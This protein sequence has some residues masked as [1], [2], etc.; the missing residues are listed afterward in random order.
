MLAPSTRFG[1]RIDEHLEDAGGFVRLDGAADARKRHRR[2]LVGDALLA[3]TLFVQSDAGHFGIGERDV[4][5]R[6]RAPRRGSV[7]P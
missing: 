2:E 5:I 3:S 1:L 6:A 4:G 7:D